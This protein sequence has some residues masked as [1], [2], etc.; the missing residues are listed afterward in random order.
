MQLIDLTAN[1]LKALDDR[2]LRLSGGHEHLEFAVAAA[3]RRSPI[4]RNKYERICAG[5]KHLLLRQ[6]L[7][8]DISPIAHM[9]SA[10]GSIAALGQVNLLLQ[11]SIHVSLCCGVGLLELVL[12][13]NNVSQVWM[14]LHQACCSIIRMLPFENS[15]ECGVAA[16][17]ERFCF[18][19]EAG[20]LNKPPPQHGPSLHFAN[21]SVKGA[22]FDQ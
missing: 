2:V 19:R 10:S 16:R 20:P 4:S 17:P 1:R 15:I 5:L 13:D 3:V 21:T 7:L 12:Y 6:N 9:A 11:C 18:T 22:I 14:Y 8:E